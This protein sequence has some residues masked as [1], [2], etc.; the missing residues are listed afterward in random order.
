[1][2]RRR[3]RRE[4]AFTLIELLVVIAIIAIL[5]GLLLPAVQKIR[6]AANR[7]KCSNNLKQF[8]L[9]LH[10]YH[11]VNGRFPPG[12]MFGQDANGNYPPSNQDWNSNQG[13]WIVFTL[14]F[15]EQDN[16][17]RQLNPRL[18]V[19]D[20]VDP[21]WTR[22][23]PNNNVTRLNASQLR[24][25]ILRCPSD[26]YDRNATV[27]NYVGSLGPAR[28]NSGFG[29][30][31]YNIWGLGDQGAPGS[32]GVVY[33]YGPTANNGD[34]WNLNNFR[35]VF[36]RIGDEITMSSITDGLSNTIMVGESLPKMHDHLA[37][38]LWWDFN[39]GVA[40]ASTI[41]P[42]NQRSDGTSDCSPPAYS[43]RNWNVSWGFKSRH[44]GGANFL[45]G[46]ASVHFLRDSIDMRT[47]QLLGC[48]NDGQTPGNY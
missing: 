5:I 9:A 47:Y 12:G 14:P 23:N 37:Q 36:N 20:S 16:L 27:S 42:I 46:D 40:H 25:S 11:D 34:D 32:P 17:Y 18:S 15:I 30:D 2:L 39:G 38:N 3:A 24:L 29:C 13:T 41:V 45:F 8:G 26:D 48:R 31:P 1:M 10:N 7:M 6:E 19:V 43:P 35:G 28:D 4:C 22:V 33:G 44:S 21:L